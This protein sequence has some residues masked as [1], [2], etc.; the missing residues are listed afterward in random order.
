MHLPGSFP[1]KDQG[2]F[3]YERLYFTPGNLGFPVFKVA[4][5]LVGV[6]ICHDRN[7][8]EGYRLLALRGAELVFTPAK[9]AGRRKG[10]AERHLGDDTQVARVR[11]RVFPRR[12]RQG[13]RRGR[14]ALR[15]RFHRRLPAR[16]DVVARAKT[17]ATE[18]VLAEIDL[19]DVTEARTRMP[20]A[21]DRRPEHYR[22]LTTP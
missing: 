15:R 22:E 5:T 9:H 11:E 2:A 13:R 6:Q 7:F 17:D 1:L 19:D 12:R 8:P 4:G 3:T 10:L 16:R 14:P 20:F 18:V 21:R